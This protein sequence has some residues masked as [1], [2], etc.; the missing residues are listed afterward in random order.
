[1]ASKDDWF[2]E[3]WTADNYKTAIIVQLVI[4]LPA[5]FVLNVYLGCYIKNY[6]LKLEVK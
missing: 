4:G 3:N 1:M 2:E 5:L 6:V